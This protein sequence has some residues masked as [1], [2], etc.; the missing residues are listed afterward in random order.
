MP[1]ILSLATATPKY[2][3]E[4]ADIATLMIKKLNLSLEQEEKLKKIYKNSSIE[5]RYSVMKNF[6]LL[7]SKPTSNERND[8]YKI[9]APKLAINAAKKAIEQWGESPDNIT[10]VISV[11]CTGMMAP[12]I[13]YFLIKELGLRASVKRLG[14]NFMGCFG[15]FNGLS[16]ARAIA[17]ESSHHR[18]LLVCTEL[19]SLHGQVNPESYLSNALFADG[20]AACI[21]GEVNSENYL[22]KIIDHSSLLIDNSYH[23]MSWDISESGF[24]MKLSRKVPVLIKQ[25]ITPFVKTILNEKIAF[26][27]CH[28]AI[29]P[30]G[31]AILQ[32]I[33]DKCT[34]LSWQTHCSWKVLKGYGNMSSATFLFLLDQLIAFRNE[35]KLFKMTSEWILGLAFGP[36]LAVEGI[37]LRHR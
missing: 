17:R 9:E 15:A 30:G 18:I 21:V 8:I 28:W 4:Q 12:G 36:G 3:F 10:H 26:E 24:A 13:E 16:V 35:N 2:C 27:E 29:H 6:D 25:N 22:L 37:F 7:F 33:E 20:A 1:A 5:T 19:C 23:L 14:I 32:A 11:S 34:L 31:K